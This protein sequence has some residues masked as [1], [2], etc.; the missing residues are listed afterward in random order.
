MI[1]QEVKAAL[2]IFAR[3]H[4]DRRAVQVSTLSD[5]RDGPVLMLYYEITLILVTPYR[6]DLCTRYLSSVLIYI[7]LFR[8]IQTK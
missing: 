1:D 4:L 2:S 3:S 8:E 7:F 5:R 6:L